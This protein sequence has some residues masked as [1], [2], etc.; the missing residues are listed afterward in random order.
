MAIRP[1]EFYPTPRD[2]YEGLPIDWSLFSKA[3][4]PCAGDFRLVYFMQQKGLEV[5]WAELAHG[6]D[7]LETSFYDID[8]VFTNPPFSKALEFFDKALKEAPSVIMLQ[9]LNFLASQKRASW[10]EANPPT[11]LIVLSKRPSFTGAKKTDMTD[12]CWYIWD[13]TERLPR[14]ISFFSPK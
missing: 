7:Y 10:W 11:G 8:L 9:R 1:D 5:E 13:K 14:G 3:L 12:Y 6:I 4:E 2:S